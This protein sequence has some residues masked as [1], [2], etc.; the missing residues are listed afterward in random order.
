MP[1][2]AQMHTS[3]QAQELL[4]GLTASQQAA[5]QHIDGPMMVLAGPG[6]GKTRV[7]T[8][9]IAY[10][11]L[12]GISAQQIVGLTFTNKAAEEMKSRLVNLSP[13]ES[14]WMGTFHRFCARLLRQYASLIGLEDNFTIYDAKDSLNLIKRTVEEEQIRLY[15]SSPERIAK[16]I[17]RAKQD[18]ISSEAFTPRPGDPTDRL[19]L[20]VYSAYQKR[21]LSCNAVDFDD[22]L[23]HAAN[24]LSENSELRHHLDIRYRYILVDE[25]QDTNYAQY[26]ILRALSV[27]YPNLS[28]TGDPDQSIYSWRGADINNIL[29][30]ENDFPGTNVVRL[31]QNYRSTQRILRVADR[32][33]AHNTRRKEKLLFTENEEGSPVRIV[34]YADERDEATGIAGKISEAIQTG[35]RRPRDFAIFYRINAL[36][37]V[38]EQALYEQGVPY[39]I[40]NGFEF[41]QRQEIKDVLA[42]LHLIN[43]PRNDVAMERII[44]RPSRGIG[45][46]T[47]QRI[48]EYAKQYG[49]SLFDAS[50]QA[51]LLDSLSGKPAKAVIA[52]VQLIERLITH[53]R[54]PV[55]EILGQIISLS[56]Y[57][58]Q[59]KD[60]EAPEDQDRLDNINELLSAAR[61]FDEEHSVV[62]LDAFLEQASLVSDTD[63]FEVE[64]DQV[65]L[66]TLHAAK[67]LEFP[68]VF[69]VAVE[70][71]LLPHERSL[72][73]FDQLEEE[74]RL[75]FV[76]ITRACQSLELS[77][78]R[79]R[80]FRGNR[81]PAI[82]SSFL[83][84]IPHG[85]LE[86]YAYDDSS[87][88]MTDIEPT[89]PATPSVRHKGQ[90]DPSSR[91][92]STAIHGGLV[93][94]AELA[95]ATTSDKLDAPRT[96][97]DEFH[98]GMV[99]RHPKYD[100]GKVMALSGSHERRTATI[101]FFGGAGERK[102]RLHHS[103]IHPVKTPD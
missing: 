11:L 95:N 79:R 97:P 12:Q 37:R 72:Q 51:E 4:H 5:V 36:S 86:I 46:I 25:Y 88:V 63:A 102:I 66:M 91:E 16:G 43:N 27:D 67:G 78:C 77:I 90:Q 64:P 103:S 56:G 40:V 101:Q 59:L 21:L 98:V 53:T 24:L 14:I 17:S 83:M 44:N 48:S 9:R 22:L 23:M 47:L 80:D 26:T 75:L 35:R 93:T 69:I 52:F 34:A 29:Q 61:Q 71:R 38:F 55:E 41:Y 60:S 19:V 49:L 89:Q 28:V 7:V 96:N 33:I 32:L 31:E 99:V 42:Y 54:E 39:Q 50:R 8:H 73:D 87:I 100:L 65:T 2:H 92:S 58:D 76:G 82:P 18:L 6:S 45:R 1:Y 94:A 10:L 20:D 70:E 15:K 30:F 62:G 74:R 68:E 3:T 84:E 13:G 81:R 57:A 85:E